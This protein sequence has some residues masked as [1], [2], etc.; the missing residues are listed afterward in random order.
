MNDECEYCGRSGELRI[1]KGESG[2]NRDVFICK[3]CWGLLKDPRTALPLL[4]GH[5]TL[6]QRE[7]ANPEK[8]EKLLNKFM[9]LISTWKPHN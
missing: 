2:I 7:M 4:R 5:L 1:S 3:N 9:G 6:S 8:S